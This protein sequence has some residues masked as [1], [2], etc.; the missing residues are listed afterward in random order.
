MKAVLALFLAAPLCFGAVQWVESGQVVTST[1]TL[2]VLPDSMNRNHGPDFRF[3]LQGGTWTLTSIYDEDSKYASMLAYVG[4]LSTILPGYTTLPGSNW[5]H[6][7]ELRLWWHPDGS[8]QWIGLL[9]NPAETD[10]EK[11]RYHAL[12]L[13]S[14]N[15]DNSL[16]IHRWGYE[17]TPGV[18]VEVPVPELKPGWLLAVAAV[19]LLRRRRRT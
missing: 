14:W 2:Q 17:D 19:L 3:S 18:P 6:S 13:L 16:T 15:V 7:A 10:L 12:L 9:P 1:A 4:I 5:A 11:D 8:A